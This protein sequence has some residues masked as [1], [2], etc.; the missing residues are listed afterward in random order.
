MYIYVVIVFIFDYIQCVIYKYCVPINSLCVV[1]MVNTCT[2]DRTSRYCS[3]V[4]SASP[5]A[6]ACEKNVLVISR[7]RKALIY[8]IKNQTARLFAQ[9]AVDRLPLLHTL[10]IRY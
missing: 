3:R 7:K 2:G 4:C 1:S 10:S 5:Q 6:Q 8:Y 9:S